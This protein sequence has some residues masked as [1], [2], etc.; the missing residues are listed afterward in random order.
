[1]PASEVR[2]TTRKSAPTYQPSLVTYRNDPGPSGTKK[3]SIV[4]SSD[5]DFPVPQHRIVKKHHKQKVLTDPPE[6]I[7]LSSGDDN[8]PHKP[9]S[10][11][12]S[13]LRM[14]LEEARKEIKRL[15]QSEQEARKEIQRLHNSS[16]FK[17]DELQ[18]AAQS[19]I[20]SEQEAQREVQRLRESAQAAEELHQAIV[21]SFLQ[22]EQETKEFLS[23]MDEH[24]TC[25]LCA[26]KMWIPFVLNCGHVFCQSCL[27]KWFDTMHMQHMMTYPD[28]DPQA[29]I[30]PNYR[31][32]LE[33]PQTPE[34]VRRMIR[35]ELTVMQESQPRYTCPNCRI[36]IRSKPIEVFT[37]RDMVHSVAGAI[38]KEYER[39]LGFEQDGLVKDEAE[40]EVEAANCEEGQIRA[41]STAMRSFSPTVGESSAIG[42]PQAILNTSSTLPPGAHNRAR[43]RSHQN[44]RVDGSTLTT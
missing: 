4:L 6:V 24:I 29:M 32:A 27:E 12:T 10:I 33:D 42:Y 14:E 36:V 1:M 41:A 26:S 37:L 19:S 18:A 23:V 40:Q 11:S 13:S 20:H 21:Q 44:V 5:D 15:Q 7:E 28:Y 22:T 35:L 30:S 17:E 31:Y 38:A 39:K 16:Q 3:C 8:L 9:S 34:D 2:S 25:Q 43:T